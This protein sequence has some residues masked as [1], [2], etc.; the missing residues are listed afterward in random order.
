MGNRILLI[1]DD[2]QECESW[3][4]LLQKLGFQIETVRTEAGVLSQ[5]LSLRPDAVFLHGRGYQINPLNVLEKLTNQTWFS[6]KIILFESQQYPLYVADLAQFRFDGLLPSTV[7]DDIEKLEIIS[8]TLS[9]SFQALFDKY[10]A[11]FGVH[12][13]EKSNIAYRTPSPAMGAE[14]QLANYRLKRSAA[15]PINGHEVKSSLSKEA[16]QGVIKPSLRIA[17]IESDEL[18]LQKRE[19]VRALF[20]KD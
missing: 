19:F 2:Y 15:A 17:S 9:I 3:H 20:V 12:H 5:L 13:L 6:G 11:I 14:S 1:F 10:Q 7:F 16:I 4:Q 18:I 8:Q